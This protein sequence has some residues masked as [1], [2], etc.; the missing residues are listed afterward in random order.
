M[1]LAQPM[2]QGARTAIGQGTEEVEHIEEI[3][4]FQEG[5]GLDRISDLVCNVLKSYFIK[6]TQDICRRHGI[7]MREQK[8]RN[9][10]WDGV[11]LR[12]RGEER[13]ELPYNPFLNCPVLLCPE[14]FLKELMSM[15]SEDF[16]DW[17]SKQEEAE[18]LRVDFHFDLSRRVPASVRSRLARQHPD[19]VQRYLEEKEAEEKKPYDLEGDPLFRVRAYETAR[20]L[21]DRNPLTFTPS[22]P[23][24]FPEFIQ[25][26]IE[27]FQHAVEESDLWMH[28]WR[29]D[30]F[31]SERAVQSLFR[32]TAW[33]YCQAV[34][35]DMTAEANAGRGPVD[36]KFVQNWKSR[37]LLEIKL[38]SNPYFWNGLTKQTV[39]YL[40]SEGIKLGYFVY[41]IHAERHV[42]P[43]LTVRAK[44]LAK[45][46]S[47]RFGLDVRTAQIDAR[48]KLSASKLKEGKGEVVESPSAELEPIEGFDE[49][50]D[51]E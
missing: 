41:V 22:G 15:D 23:E 19:L 45:E 50:T 40:K 4:L 1:K 47:S 31:V 44:Q 20:D 32:H 46:V 2:L 14:R 34:G 21:A 39:Q 38:A 9:A 13:V 42:E 8:V 18:S 10:S 25:A 3:I 28:L 36:F 26:I 11:N 29:D 33:H 5:M 12:W 49:E 48:R 24:Q 51:L 30:R 37:A 16:W 17:A 6:Y 43:E 27:T 35:I 7:E